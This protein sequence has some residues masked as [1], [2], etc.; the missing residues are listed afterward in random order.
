M[1][2]SKNWFHGEIDVGEANKLLE[3]HSVGT[4]LVRF[5][6]SHPRNYTISSVEYKNATTLYDSNVSNSSDS[7]S[8]NTST[9]TTSDDSGNNANNSTI[10]S[11]QRVSFI[12]GNGFSFRNHL[13]P[14]LDEIINRSTSLR[15]V[16][17]GSPFQSLFVEVTQ[18]PGNGY[19]VNL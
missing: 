2:L 4:F 17:P 16:C 15:F 7:N 8:S 18:R 11:H 13:Y 9:N 1:L 5:S 12:A 19:I 6:S 10:I 3:G 14:S